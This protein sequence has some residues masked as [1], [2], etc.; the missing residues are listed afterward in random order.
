MTNLNLKNTASRQINNAKEHLETDLIDHLPT[1]TMDSGYPGDRVYIPANVSALPAQ[2]LVVLVPLGIRDQI[3]FTH[4]IW[5]L[6][7]HLEIPVLFLALAR[8]DQTRPLMHRLLA[9][10]VNGIN[11]GKVSAERV[12]FVGRNWLAALEQT[13]LPGD[14]VVCLATQK[15]RRGVVFQEPLGQLLSK[16]YDLPVLELSEL[17]LDSTVNMRLVMREAL[18]WGIALGTIGIFGWWQI[19]LSLS[20]DQ[21]FSNIIL[22]QVAAFAILFL[23]KINQISSPH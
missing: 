9:D 12:V 23:W 21:P 4:R 16:K 7:E 19:H 5:E 13:T 10:M 2:R 18:V 20:S 8:L 6:A 17:A 22:I 3:A 15:M 11:Y 14:L 1:Y